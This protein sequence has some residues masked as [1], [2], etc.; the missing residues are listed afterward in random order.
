MTKLVKFSDVIEPN[1]KTI[2]ENNLE[3]KHK[4]PLGTLV[5]VKY[6]KQYGNGAC[7]KRHDRLFVA[8]HTRDCDGTP[9]YTLANSPNY[10][11]HPY[12]SLHLTALYDLEFVFSEESL[13]IVELTEEIKK[14]DGTLRWKDE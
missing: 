12:D 9:L 7:S 3:K 1:G 4:I 5:E 10:L 2:K 13:T 11:E 8:K 14:G 6:T